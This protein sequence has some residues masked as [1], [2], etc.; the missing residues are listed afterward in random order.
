MR[1]KGEMS[2]SIA[3]WIGEAE[4]RKF[5][6]YPIIMRER[7]AALLYADSDD[8]NFESNALELLATVAGAM[9]EILA[10][11]SE[12]RGDLVTIA[13]AAQKPAISAWFSL[14]RDEQDLHSRAQRFA[15]VQVAEMRLYQSENVKN[16]RTARNLYASLKTE[17]DSAREGFRRDFL[18][19]PGTMVDYL[20][21]ELVRTLANEDAE[22]LGP[23]YPGPLL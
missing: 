2:Q 12:Q 22:L 21:L 8:C 3:S 23:D 9:I 16:G 20:H 10:S 1:T 6:L 19:E 5:Y 17:I 4:S 14:S 13:G 7:V 18:S 15:R 11:A